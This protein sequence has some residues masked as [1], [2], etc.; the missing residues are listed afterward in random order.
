MGG[1]GQRIGGKGKN[2]KQKNNKNIWNQV[3]VPF[4]DVEFRTQ[5]R[6]WNRY[7]IIYAGQIM[8]LL[9]QNTVQF[10]KL[11][12]EEWIKNESSMEIASVSRT[13]SRS[14][15]RPF[16]F[17]RY[18]SI[19]GSGFGQITSSFDS[20]NVFATATGSVQKPFA[21]D[22]HTN[23]L[24]GFWHESRNTCTG[25]ELSLKSVVKPWYLALRTKRSWKSVHFFENSGCISLHELQISNTN[26][27]R[28]GVINAT[29]CISFPVL[30]NGFLIS[31]ALIIP[32][33]S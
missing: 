12:K 4:K 18:P 9:V 14:K 21:F 29:L 32:N 13:N 10:F 22:N 6:P 26:W 16:A 27:D 15:S 24:S 2:I 30:E 28:R 7:R 19:F 23:R 31:A 33:K 8:E 1:K 25:L 11:V 20:T 5:F 17:L 3:T